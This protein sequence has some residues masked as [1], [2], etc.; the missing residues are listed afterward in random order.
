MLTP[1]KYNKGKVIV[2]RD[3]ENA[4]RYFDTGDIPLPDEVKEYHRAKL[5][6]REAREGRKI[7]F[8]TVVNDLQFASV[9][10]RNTR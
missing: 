2:A 8:N 9:F 1:W 3:A 10:K 6:E 7:D 4:V 5:A